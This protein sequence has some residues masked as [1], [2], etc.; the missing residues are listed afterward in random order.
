M[1]ESWRLRQAPVRRVLVLAAATIMIFGGAQFSIAAPEAADNVT[2]LEV[3]QAYTFQLNELD[4]EPKEGCG[5]GTSC[6]TNLNKAT[7]DVDANLRDTDGSLSPAAGLGWQFDLTRSC[8]G[9]SESATF[10][11]VFS[12]DADSTI[13]PVVGLG[14]SSTAVFARAKPGGTAVPGSVEGTGLTVNVETGIA[15]GSVY[16]PTLFGQAH[17]ELT[18]TPVPGEQAH[19]AVSVLPKKVQILWNDP[20]PPAIK[21]VA[22]IP[23]GNGG[24]GSTNL[25]YVGSTSVRI[26]ARA[27]DPAVQDGAFI[28]QSCVKDIKFDIGTSSWDVLVGEDQGA[29]TTPELLREGRYDFEL[30]PED[31]MGNEPLPAARTQYFFVLDATKPGTSVG[32]DR[33][34]N[35]FL[36]DDGVT[37]WYANDTPIWRITCIRDPTGLGDTHTAPCD[38]NY[39]ST[40]GGATYDAGTEVPS[41][42]LT[43]KTAKTGSSVQIHA[44]STDLS[45]QTA[46]P[47]AGPV[48]KVDVEKPDADFPRTTRSLYN[49]GWHIDNTTLTVE[50]DGDNISGCGMIVTRRTEDSEPGTQTSF[51]CNTDYETTVSADVW[52]KA[53][54]L[55]HSDE[56][57]GCDYHNPEKV[58]GV[59]PVDWDLNP[60]KGVFYNED[61]L[62]TYVNNT[63]K[64]SW[65]P[66]VDPIVNG[67]HSDIKGYDILFNGQPDWSDTNSYL[68]EAYRQG[69]N[70]LYVRAVDNAGRAGEWSAMS[71]VF[72]DT[73]APTA[74]YV[75][76]PKAALV[77]NGREI[78]RL[79]SA[80]DQ[81][82]E[83]LVIGDIQNQVTAS[84]GG[85]ALYNIEMIV[86]KYPYYIP[87]PTNKD[88]PAY[89]GPA[90]WDV[91]SDDPTDERVDDNGRI[92]DPTD[93]TERG[94]DDVN[95]ASRTCVWDDDG[96]RGD[97]NRQEPRKMFARIWDNANNWKFVFRNYTVVESL[98]FEAACTTLD[99]VCTHIGFQET[100]LQNAVRYLIH[101]GTNPDF[102]P[103]TTNLVGV[104]PIGDTEV[105]DLLNGDT[106]TT[107]YYKVLVE[108]D[109]GSKPQVHE[110]TW[111]TPTN[112]VGHVG[113]WPGKNVAPS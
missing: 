113:E 85:S 16:E 17:A 9:Q 82:S 60:K 22:L 88:D 41:N 8:V 66:G 58:V 49:N 7:I 11:L 102:E 96:G 69:I 56:H 108:L 70:R 13:D 103:T 99:G 20:L 71:Q 35:G 83:T 31:N 37:Y 28:V 3:G 67:V 91:L 78:L 51:S 64:W 45:T 25:G 105:E 54:N 104:S 27:E 97:N 43:T 68:G 19:A 81:F 101:A 10:T 6:R 40:D 5:V 89:W 39:V 32:I 57:F 98:A 77:L 110:L 90:D 87:N 100:D 18:N 47:I 106:R 24:D 12:Y 73:I 52:D 30:V 48:I 76:P 84:D 62:T 86:D 92:P 1:K 23:A 38:D 74:D 111:I 59:L 34:P 2:H 95:L 93:P 15:F 107:Y 112:K 36:S 65:T 46:S 29:V 55:V 42:G 63:P 53:G 80:P 61:R 94:C 44:K 4:V 33:A 109:D 26:Q 21:E 14:K 72:V 79:P 75:W 50:C